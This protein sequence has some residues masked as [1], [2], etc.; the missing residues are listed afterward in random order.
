MKLTGN[1]VTVVI[2]VYTEKRWK[3]MLAAFESVQRQSVPPHDIIIVVDHNP[4]LAQR[5][6]DAVPSATVI[7]NM[8]QSGLSGGRNT[9]LDHSDTA[10][11]AF[12]DDDA[13]AAP[14]WIE[15]LLWH[16]SS[17]DVAG[18]GG[19]VMP[20]WDGQRPPWFPDEFGWT[21]GCS[22]R[23]MPQIVTEVR[24]IFGGCACLR[25]DLVEAVNGY[26]SEL[27]RSDTSLI[28]CEDTQL[29]IRIHE[30]FPQSRFMH[31]PRAKIYHHVPAQRATWRYF[32]ERCFA[33]GISKAVMAKTLGAEQALSTERAYT[34]RTLPTAVVRALGRVLRHGDV[35]GIA[36]AA[37]IACGLVITVAG[38]INASVRSA[39][40]RASLAGH[41][42]D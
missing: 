13:V 10:L 7:E 38:Y 42:P 12:L 28:S 5:L 40:S 15:R 34:M 17:T 33:E 1:D 20:I 41:V 25:R 9:A 2:N 31:E 29:C 22:Y 39:M 16:F 4:S 11:I 32:C 3:E 19:V 18:V 36:T 6:I 30:R 27:G 21:V 8:F 24:N 35:W 26:H 37:A 23:G 14:D